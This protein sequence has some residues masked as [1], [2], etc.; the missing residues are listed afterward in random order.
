MEQKYQF[1]FVKIANL[2]IYLNQVAIIS[3]GKKN[4]LLLHCANCGFNEFIGEEKTFDTWMDSS[5]TPLFISKFSQD[6]EFY[7]R[8]YPATIRPQAKDIIRTWLYY[9]ML[10]CYQLTENLPWPECLDNGLWC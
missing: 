5:I 7:S 6:N 1:G 10:R 4:R 8:T 2:L 3:H 9:T